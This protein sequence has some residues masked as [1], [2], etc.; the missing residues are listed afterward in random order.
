MQN[1]QDY[2]LNFDK[3][4]DSAYTSGFMK[5]SNTRD[6]FNE[7]NSEKSGAGSLHSLRNPSAIQS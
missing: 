3:E 7:E 6:K 5:H 2:E 4:S 1:S